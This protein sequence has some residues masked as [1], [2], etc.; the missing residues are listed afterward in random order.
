MGYTLDDWN[1][2]KDSLSSGLSIR[3]T[4]A[5]T[6]VDRGA[7]F[8]WLHLEKPPVYMFFRE[9]DA[10]DMDAVSLRPS[11]KS[12]LTPD[13]RIRIEVML[14]YGESKSVIAKRLG[15]D[16]S[17]VY[18]EIARCKGQPSYNARRAHLDA[19][20]N[21][22][23]PKQRKVA[24]SPRL[25]GYIVEKLT[26]RWSPYE[27]SKRLAI[28]FPDDEEMRVSH[29]AIYQA[30]YIQ[31]KGSLRQEVALEKAL[32]SG[33]TARKPRSRLGVKRGGGS[34]VDGCEISKRPP[35]VEDRAI[36]GH[37][38]GD[39]VIGGDQKSCLLTLV[40]RK[41]RFLVARRFLCHDTAT[42]VDRLIDMARSIP[43]EMC[44]SLLS[45]LTWDQGSEMADAARFT[46]ATGCKVYFCDPRSPWQNGTNENT[47]GLIRQYFPKGT[48]FGEV[49]DEEVKRMQ[50]SLNGRPRQ[51]LGFRTPAEA[52]QEE[53][54]SVVAMTA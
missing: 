7:V 44:D 22:R 12:R 11:P 1:A 36:P 21:A 29:E 25:R 33:R 5:S 9:K 16:R 34:W 2:V 32:R 20:G 52:L 51:T 10:M 39:L 13:M 54:S 4:A 40:E 31:G 47:N 42:I 24:A 8:R 48:K 23:R 35:E 30:L 6:G 45:T 14:Q 41:T 37:W 27:I 50:D 17:T 38:E 53:L 26:E 46:L 3:D 28:E 19:L 15:I 43:D 49:T 18:R